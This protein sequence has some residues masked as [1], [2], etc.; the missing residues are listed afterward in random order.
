TPS[1]PTTLLT[2]ARIP[3]PDTRLFHET[4]QSAE[5]VDESDL[6]QWDFDPP[7][8]SPEPPDTAAEVRFTENLIDVMH[9]RRCRQERE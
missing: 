8:H 4:C 3:L 5:A 6:P 2:W 9:G 7:Y 1:L